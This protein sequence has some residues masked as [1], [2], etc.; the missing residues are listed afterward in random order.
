MVYTIAEI[1]KALNAL[2]PEYDKMEFVIMTSIAVKGPVVDAEIRPGIGMAVLG[3][4]AVCIVAIGPAERIVGLSA[5]QV[6]VNWPA[7]SPSVVDAIHERSG[8]E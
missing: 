8:S 4:R 2:G 3:D 1:K 5:E 6:M 7:T